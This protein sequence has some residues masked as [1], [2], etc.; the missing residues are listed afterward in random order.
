V[1]VTTPASSFEMSRSALSSRSTD[2]NAVSAL[3]T[4]GTAL[5][6]SSVSARAPRKSRAAFRGWRRSC[7]AAAR[8]RVL[9]EVGG[10]G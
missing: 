6:G 4:S 1:G 8:K 3:A 5:F 7:E 2:S 10:L 9:G